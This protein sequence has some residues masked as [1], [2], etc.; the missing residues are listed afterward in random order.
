MRSVLNKHP[1]GTASVA[2]ETV[3]IGSWFWAHVGVGVVKPLGG[4]RRAQK[5]REGGSDGEA[6]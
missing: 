2:A 4:R 5:K 1:V 6:K 3:D